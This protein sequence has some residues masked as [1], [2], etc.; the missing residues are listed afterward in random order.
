MPMH[1][2][3]IRNKETRIYF[4]F[5]YRSWAREERGARINIRYKVVSW[6]NVYDNEYNYIHLLHIL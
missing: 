6:L 5:P 2:Y 4:L 3:G 1:S